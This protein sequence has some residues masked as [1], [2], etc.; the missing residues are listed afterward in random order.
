MTWAR[1]FRRREH[2][3]GSLWFVPFLAAVAGPLLAELCVR[4]EGRVSL[5]AQWEYSSG[6]ASTV[7]T[8]IVGAMVAL[9]GFVVTL[10][11]LICL[12]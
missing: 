3:R 10:G 11:V 5:P 6:T 9:T 12:L 1:T 4:L 7:L 8:A 2:L